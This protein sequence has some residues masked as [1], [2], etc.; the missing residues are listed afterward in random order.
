MGILG[1][2][3]EWWRSEQRGKSF[4]KE[5]KLGTGVNVRSPPRLE[6]EADT[7]QQECTELRP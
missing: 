5:G 2:C 4:S 6:I 1:V 3:A 7:S